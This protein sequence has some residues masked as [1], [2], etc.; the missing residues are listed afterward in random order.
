MNA[1]TIFLVVVY[2]VG[3]FVTATV[4]HVKWGTATSWQLIANFLCSLIW[5]TFVVIVPAYAVTCVARWVA[6][7]GGWKEYH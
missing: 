6:K 3:V 4:L 5:P 1:L 2:S 7:V